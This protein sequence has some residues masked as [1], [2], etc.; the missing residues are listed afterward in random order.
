MPRDLLIPSLVELSGWTLLLIS[1]NPAGAALIAA[2]EAYF[3][4]QVILFN[5]RDLPEDERASWPEIAALGSLLGL[6]VAGAGLWV[7][8]WPVGVVFIATAVL[9]MGS[10][11]FVSDEADFRF[12]P[13]PFF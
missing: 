13:T 7:W 1:R 2:A 12:P 11:L 9:L 3:L 5:W 6:Y 4:A 8:S 10:W